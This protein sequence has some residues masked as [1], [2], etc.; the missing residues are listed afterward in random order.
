[1]S[2]GTVLRDRHGC[3]RRVSGKRF[4]RRTSTGL[5]DSGETNLGSNKHEA[6][7]KTNDENQN[8]VW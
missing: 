1:M 8:R 4:E 6:V 2:V 7:R 5:N 3:S